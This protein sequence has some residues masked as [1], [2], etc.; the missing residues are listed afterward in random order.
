MNTKETNHN[1]C[2]CKD[3]G[4]PEHYGFSQCR[5][6]AMLDLYR[7]DMTDETGTGFCENCASDAMESGMFD[8]DEAT[9]DLTF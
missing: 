8:T 6:V 5:N 1:Y 3:T 7:T 9:R 2:K 4:C